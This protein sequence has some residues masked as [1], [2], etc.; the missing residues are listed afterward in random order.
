MIIK[1]QIPFVKVNNILASQTKHA[2]DLLTDLIMKEKFDIII[3]LGTYKGGLTEFLYEF[4]KNL[5]SY[6]ISD[7]DLESKN[8]NINFRIGN[9]LE[10][11]TINE[12]KQLVKDKKALILCDGGDKE[13]EFKI[14]SEIIEDGSYIMAHDFSHDKLSYET[15]KNNVKW[16]S[17]AECYAW[18]LETCIS[19]GIL[20]QSSYYSKFLSAF[21]GCFIK[22]KYNNN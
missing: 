12:I 20:H 15:H 10:E 4:N 1:E 3:E 6:D 7:K 5:V 18:N 19:T 16:P 2:L 8:K 17:E 21:W 14:Y 22:R 11:N 13:K 9:S